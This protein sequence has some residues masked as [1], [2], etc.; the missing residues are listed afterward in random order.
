[1]STALNRNVISNGHRKGNVALIINL[2][3]RTIYLRGT[4]SFGTVLIWTLVFSLWKKFTSTW[5]QSTCRNPLQA[6][7]CLFDFQSFTE[8]PV[9]EC[10]F[11]HLMILFL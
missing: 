2:H 8:E 5:N 10:A 4:V 6:S 9:F 11:A 7:Q 3:P 1:L